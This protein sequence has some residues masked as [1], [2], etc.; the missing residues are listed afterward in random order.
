[1]D[2]TLDVRSLPDCIDEGPIRCDVCIVGSGPAGA[3]LALE[4]A[5]TSLDV[6]LAESGHGGRDPGIDALSEIDNVGWPRTLD[7]SLTRSRMLGGTSGLWTGRCAN[8][9]GIDYQRRAWVP[10]SGWP[11]P[12]GIMTP[13]LDRSAPHLGLGPGSDYTGELFWKLAGRE[14][15]EPKL[16]SR[17]LLPMF[18]QF[19]QD[20]ANRRTS[21]RFARR[22]LTERPANLR[23]VTH[24]TA[25][26]VDADDACAEVRAVELAAPNDSRCKV[27]ARIVV[28]CAGGIENARLLLASNRQQAAGLGNWRGAVGRF[29]MDHP[30]GSVAVF[31]PGRI[32]ELR[33]HFGIR[34]VHTVQGPRMFCQ[35]M[36]LSPRVQEREGLT[37]C[38]VWLSEHVAPDDPWSALKRLA[39][40]RGGWLD[41]LRVASH[42][43][44]V[45][46]GA[47]GVW[48]T[49]EGVPRRLTGLE[50]DCAVEQAPDPDSR[51]T[52]SERTDR[53]GMPLSR[54]DWRVGEQEQRTAR[55]AADL[56]IGELRRLGV[57][58]PAPADWVREERPFP[59]SF[60]D[61]AHHIGTTRMSTSSRT[62]VVDADCQVHGVHGLFVAGS[63]VFPTGGH[64]NPTQMIVAMAIRLADTIKQRAWAPRRAPTT[65]AVTE[66]GLI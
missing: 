15:T 48:A 43:L 38:A 17:K 14:P 55:R 12:A 6:V 35:G 63:S 22:L 34:T 42:P 18:W 19:S 9:D 44:M 8:F 5:H 3:T 10:H 13:Y 45:A 29:L 24:A 54:L 61:V 28:L 23:V 7:Q 16:D 64:A 32:G 49:G 21:M 2:A 58:A 11:F 66:P 56:A 60:Q 39:L 33:G 26:H 62:G 40:R 47:Y 37:N 65:M 59:A 46:R 52:L 41:G 53:H 51:V 27:N 4:L 50:L 36:R 1:M 25:V 20:P 31:D 30:R 57:H